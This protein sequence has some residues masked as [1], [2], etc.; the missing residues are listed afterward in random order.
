MTRRDEPIDQLLSETTPSPDEV[1]AALAGSLEAERDA[2]STYGLLSTLGSP[3]APEVAA[4]KQA[5]VER[6]DSGD[7]GPVGLSV[8]R[9]HLVVAVVGL[10]ALVLMG[11]ALSL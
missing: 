9:H 3:T 8:G 5:V 6:L 1:Q 4:L 2:P 11:L 7:T 10:V